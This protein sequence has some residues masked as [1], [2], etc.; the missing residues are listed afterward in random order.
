MIR[1]RELLGAVA[2]RAQL[3]D[4]DD[5]R[6]AVK[7]V[8]AGIAHWSDVPQRQAIAEALPTELRYIL[9]SPRPTVG[10]D[11]QRFLQFVAFVTDTSPEGARHDTQAV[12]SYLDGADPRV[13]ELLR[14]QLPAEFGQLFTA[15]PPGP[16]P[17]E[18]AAAPAPAPVTPAPV[19][20]EPITPGPITPGPITPAPVTPGPVTPEQAAAEPAPAPAPAPVEL[21]AGD[22]AHVLARLPGWRGTTRRLSRT[23]ALP[24]AAQAPV[25]DRIHRAETEL[26]HH[27]QLRQGPD[28]LTVT[29]WTHSRDAVTDLDVRLAE[30]ISDILTRL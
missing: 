15:P 17:P 27:A 21:T 25:V 26:D 6:S 23:V 29:L 5:A 12:L 20:P 2:E 18:P 7:A 10:G 3:A 30:R 9:E 11:L 8:L 16:R 28:D 24:A 4:E 14:A 13:T 19:T 1:Y 22:L